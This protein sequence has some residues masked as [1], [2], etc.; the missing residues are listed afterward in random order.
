MNNDFNTAILGARKKATAER[1]QQ[2]I[3]A[4]VK[5]YERVNGRRPV[6]TENHGWITLDGRFR[7]KMRVS[8]MRNA[9]DV[10]KGRASFVSTETATFNLIQTHPHVAKTTATMGSWK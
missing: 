2:I 9:L 6:V 1:T 7:S 5:E 10:L 8:E 3:D 4:Y